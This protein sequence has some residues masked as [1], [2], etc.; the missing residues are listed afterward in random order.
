MLPQV[1]IMFFASR[2]EKSI[3]SR[4]SV[5]TDYKD[6]VKRVQ[7]IE[8]LI[9]YLKN[10]PSIRLDIYYFNN[11]PINDCNIDDFNKNSE[12]W[13]KHNK[14]LEGI[15]KYENQKNKPSYANDDA[16]RVSKQLYCGC[17]YRFEKDFADKAVFIELNNKETK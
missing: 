17:N 1:N 15:K 4:D 14:F 12:Q 5:K 13:I 2:K 11:K 8:F 16:I 7:E 3:Y 10:N 9:N 6:I